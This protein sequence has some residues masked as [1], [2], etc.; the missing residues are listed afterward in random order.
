MGQSN[1]MPKV[2]LKMDRGQVECG[3]GDDEKNKMLFILS[4]LSLFCSYCSIF[5]LCFPSRFSNFFFS[6]V[7]LCVFILNCLSMITFL[8][9]PHFFSKK[10]DGD[11]TWITQ[12]ILLVNLSLFICSV[13]F[14]H[15][16]PPLI[17]W[18]VRPAS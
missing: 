7:S 18:D 14:L 13:S 8:N 17:F 16:I 11:H 15:Y 9:D 4:C 10:E 2:V 1:S 5:S 3:R 6:S 12:R